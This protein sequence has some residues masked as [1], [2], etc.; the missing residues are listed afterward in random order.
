MRHK[1]KKVKLGTDRDHKNALM[2]NLAISVIIHE[3]IK[4]TGAKAKDIQPFVERLI[5]IAKTRPEI[6][7]IRQFDS[8]LNHEDSSKKLIEVLK[9]RYKEKDSGFTRITKIGNRKG[10]NAPLVQL[11]LIN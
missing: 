7:A 11:E 5:S 2:K 1:V 8:L 9:E 3:K 4:T 6:T 10:D